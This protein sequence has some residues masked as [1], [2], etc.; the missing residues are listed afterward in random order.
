MTHPVTP[1]PYERS[2]S[3]MPEQWEARQQPYKY[4][5]HHGSMGGPNAEQD[6]HY[7]RL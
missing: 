1:Q 7:E 2:R 4:S 3:V 5:T 6:Q